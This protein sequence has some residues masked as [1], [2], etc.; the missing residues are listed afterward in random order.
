MTLCIAMAML[1]AVGCKKETDTPATP[2]GTGAAATPKIGGEL[3]ILVWSEY[4]PNSVIEG[5]EK[6][7]GVKV[8]KKE[9][10]SNEEMLNLLK[11]ESYDIVQPSE[12][13]IEYMIAK[14][15]LQ[16]IDPAKIPLMSN[17]LP[18][19]LSMSFDPGN[20]YSVPYMAGTVGI[21]Y[22]SE[23]IKEPITGFKDVFQAKYKGRLIVL[24]DSRELVS[25]ALSTLGKDMN[26]TTPANLAAVKPLL[27]AW[28]PLVAFFDSDSPKDKL[29]A[30]DADIGIVWGGEGA[31]I[32]AEEGE[33]EGKW[34][35]TLPS[36][37]A[38]LF[39]DS[40]AVPKASKNAAA[41]HAFINYILRPEVNVKIHDDFPYLNPNG[42][43]RK[44]LTPEQIG[45]VASFPP[46]DALKAMK[47]FRNIPD[48]QTAAMEELISEIKK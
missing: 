44:L 37:G 14:D 12:Y 45:N 10:G 32:L 33:A 30:G 20:K 27:E 41:A 39:I 26:D 38:H 16:P 15:M 21:I 22:N 5:F 4:I 43:G 1:L 9:Y 11:G 40:F 48:E 31:L 35:W 42:E 3:K 34:K 19:F 18:N 46:D 23:K 8:R 17:V 36:E 24:N 7:S 29:L 28:I 47:V 2:A 25:W 13:A 6:E